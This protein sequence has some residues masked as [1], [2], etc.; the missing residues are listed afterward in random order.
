[1]NDF[2]LKV[3]VVF[4]WITNPYQFLLVQALNQCQIEVE[5]D[6]RLIKEDK[7]KIFF[8]PKV[9]FLD[10]KPN[11]LHL[12]SL[13]FFFVSRNAIYYWIKFIIFCLQIALARSIGVRV[14]WTVH[15]LEDKYAGG[16]HEISPIKAAILGKMIDGF[17]VHC[18]ST[19]QAVLEKFSLYP[20]KVFTIYHGNF[21]EYYENKI[22]QHEARKI[23]TIR[24]EEFV[25]ILFGGVHRSKGVLDSIKAFQKLQQ[26]CEG[27]KM[28]ITGKCGDK[29]LQDEILSAIKG[30]SNIIFSN[31]TVP[32]DAVQTYLNASDCGLL[33]YTSFTT[34]GVALLIMSFMKPCI[35]PNSGF[36][37]DILDRDGA[38]L[39]DIKQEEGLLSAMRE[40]INNKAKLMDMG[41][42]NFKKCQ[43]WNWDYVAKEHF[44]AY[45]SCL[46]N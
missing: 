5:E 43:R 31:D 46:K 17:I 16:K 14:V 22:S 30:D 13:Q 11:V 36:F 21:I 26:E 6:I 10:K 38:F 1:M 23:L 29:K 25:F 41:K 18:D 2:K 37:K 15:E 40:C 4:E 9:L 39:Y 42:H 44:Q 34:S 33:P 8:I 20:T 3:L 32:D 28:I 19:K 12:H 35:A 24:E 45:Q 27:V 7:T